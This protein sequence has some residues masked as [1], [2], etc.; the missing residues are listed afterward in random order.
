MW[1]IDSPW[2]NGELFVALSRIWISRELALILSLIRWSSLSGK[3]LGWHTQGLSIIS[4]QILHNQYGA[5]NERLYSSWPWAC[6]APW[7]HRTSETFSA[8]IGNY[9]RIILWHWRWFRTEWL[10]LLLVFRHQTLRKYYWLLFWLVRVKERRKQRRI[11]QY[12][13][14]WKD[15]I[16]RSKMGRRKSTEKFNYGNKLTSK[17]NSKSSTSER[18]C[19]HRRKH[20]VDIAP[21]AMYWTH[22]G[23]CRQCFPRHR[24]EDREARS[25]RSRI[26]EQWDSNWR[27]GTFSIT[28]S[29]EANRPGYRSKRAANS[30]NDWIMHQTRTRKAASSSSGNIGTA[31]EPCKVHFRIIES[32]V[33]LGRSADGSWKRIAKL[34]DVR[35]FEGGPRSR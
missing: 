29:G 26:P 13:P 9:E 24:S 8:Q 27:K 23:W 3:L 10:R 14:S 7:D 21:F 25:S 6:R 18:I 5:D 33:S 22:G 1:K 35:E 34:N 20:W 2:K 28:G 32:K 31:K 19:R 15:S 11:R 16:Q 12:G 4:R 17:I 30:W